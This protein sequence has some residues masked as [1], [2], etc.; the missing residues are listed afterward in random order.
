MEEIGKDEVEVVE[1]A[2]DVLRHRVKHYGLPFEGT[3]LKYTGGE[4]AVICEQCGE[5][6][7]HGLREVIE[8]WITLCTTA[9][10]HAE[11]TGHQVAVSRWS[12]ALYGP[13]KLK[14]G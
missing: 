13:G 6:E 4:T 9:M 1:G 2:F 10:H 7:V 11:E 8:D 5:L 12:G 14:D 3:Y